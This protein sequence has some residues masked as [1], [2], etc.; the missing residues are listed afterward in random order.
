MAVVVC[1]MQ[2]LVHEAINSG[3][4]AVFMITFSHCEGISH[5]VNVLN[6]TYS[7]IDLLYNY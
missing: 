3:V 1:M 2:H 4:Y 7:Q 5:W 6:K